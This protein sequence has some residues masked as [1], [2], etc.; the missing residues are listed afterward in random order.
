MKNFN[1]N[2]IEGVDVDIETALF[3]Y[4]LA[5]ILSNDG[6]EI[7]FWYGIN[8]DEDG[9]NTFDFCSFPLDLNVQD[10]FDFAEFESV[11]SFTGTD[12]NDWNEQPLPFKISD[13]VQYYGYENIFGTTYSNG[14]TY[15]PNIKRFVYNK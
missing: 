1:M 9:Y 8:S 5:W 11:Y 4:G 10:N 3:E 12:S 7:L 13:L 15:N 6:K 14:F 2:K